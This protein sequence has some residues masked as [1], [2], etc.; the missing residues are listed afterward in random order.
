MNS[1]GRDL[2]RARADR[3]F[4]MNPPEFEPGQGSSD[5][6]NIDLGGLDMGNNANNGNGQE[7]PFGNGDGN[8]SSFNSMSQSVNSG[9]GSVQQSDWSGGSNQNITDLLNGQ[10]GAAPGQGFSV[11]QGGMPNG[12]GQPQSNS[13]LSKDEEM[14]VKTVKTGAALA[15]GGAKATSKGIKVLYEEFKESIEDNG[16]TDRFRYGGLSSKVGGIVA[17]VGFCGLLL[18]LVSSGINRDACLALMVG[19]LMASMVGFGFLYFY[20]GPHHELLEQ[21][22]EEGYYE[23]DGEG[24]MDFPQDDGTDDGG[25]DF[26]ENGEEIGDTFGDL[27]EDEEEDLFGSWGEDEED[28]E[29]T[30][31]EGGV[32]QEDLNI[33]SMVD[34]LSSE[35]MPV[36]MYTRQYLFETFSKVL[37]L[38][39]PKFSDMHEISNSSDDFIEYEDVLREAAGTVGVK[40]EDELPTLL[41]LRENSFMVQLKADRPKQCVGKEEAIAREVVSIYKYDDYGQED[42]EK[43]SVYAVVKTVGEVFFINIFLGNT[44]MV[45][46]GDIYL[47]EKS[48]VLNPKNIMPYIWGT[49]EFGKVLKCDIYKTNSFI[50]SGVPRGGK[51]WKVQS[52]LLQLCMFNSPEDINFYVFDCKDTDSDY[53]KMSRLLPHFKGFESN[54]AKILQRLRDLTS[55]DKENV[56]THKVGEAER[57]RRIINKYGKINIVDLKESHPE[58]KLPFIYVVIDEMKSL[59]SQFSKEENAEF[60]GLLGRLVSQLPNRGYRVILIP[61]RITNEIISKQIYPLVNCRAAVKAQFDEIKTGMEITRKDFPYELPNPGDMALRASEINNNKVVYCHGEAITSNNDMNCEVFRY[62]GEVWKRLC[63][64]CDKDMVGSNDRYVD[65]DKSPVDRSYETLNED[66][67]NGVS[68]VEDS[69]SIDDLDDD[70]EIPSFWK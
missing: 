32:Y 46:L 30:R 15:V 68:G 33:E 20:Y 45:S 12:L 8:F 55:T 22:E 17:G 63:P 1:S 6:W 48:F 11:Q 41:E 36:G 50:I 60:Q 16:I 64:G 37:P 44:L 4:R 19:G 42:D 23:E 61:H 67:V 35:K 58:V 7:F 38:M 5:G 34:D 69:F 47:K 66:D 24:D 21:E 51:S 65:K 18:S 62:V 40:D 54:P 56:V 39:N 59:T 28:E 14:F 27:D 10:G 52:L 43:Q 13:V 49:N 2:N 53:Y 29:D 3:D 9:N 26:E 25:L 57:R 70:D 31:V